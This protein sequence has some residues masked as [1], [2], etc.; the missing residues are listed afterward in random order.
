MKRTMKS[1]K[2]AVEVMNNKITDLGFGYRKNV[3]FNNRMSVV[4]R[5]RRLK[6]APELN[7]NKYLAPKKKYLKQYTKLSDRVYPHALHTTNVG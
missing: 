2:K 1:E 5:M 3:Q 6:R 7:I 4:K